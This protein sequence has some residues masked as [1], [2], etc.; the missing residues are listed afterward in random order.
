MGGV[1]KSLQSVV[2]DVGGGN[3][4]WVT[5][6]AEDMGPG[7]RV[8]KASLSLSEFFMEGDAAP[9]MALDVELAGGPPGVY[10]VLRADAAFLLEGMGVHDVLA[11]VCNINFAALDLA[12]APII[13]TLMIG[14]AVLVLPEVADGRRHYRVWCDPSFGEYLEQQLSVI[15]GAAGT[16]SPRAAGVTQC[17]LQE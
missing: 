14:I 6:A 15:I 9:I 10:P 16:E 5:V 11:Q 17:E 13:I 8:N 12:A 4:V 2:K 7:Q 1:V 3:K